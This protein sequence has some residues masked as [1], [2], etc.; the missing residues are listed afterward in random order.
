MP[1]RQ[2]E[3]LFFQ[4]ISDREEASPLVRDCKGKRYLRTGVRRDG[5]QSRSVCFLRLCFLRPEARDIICFLQTDTC[6]AQGPPGDLRPVKRQRPR[7]THGISRIREIQMVFQ[8]QDLLLKI[9]GCAQRPVNILVFHKSRMGRPVRID[10]PVQAEV[11]V[12]LQLSVVS[13]IPVHWLSILRRAL[14]DRVVA[15]LPDKSAAQRG[16]LLCQIQI[17]LEIAGAV[18]H[19]VAVLHQKERL[20]RRIVQIVRDL[21]VSRVHSP[22][23]VDIG[24]IEFPVG[25]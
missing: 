1:G 9:V 10:Q 14:V 25:T 2:A 8:R 4:H 22:E 3:G 19:R 11:A 18:A 7:R 13:P 5:R 16:I 15:P 21:I 24:D 23:E 12:M 6:R 17:F 20:V